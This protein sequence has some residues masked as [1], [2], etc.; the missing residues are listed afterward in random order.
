MITK[1]IILNKLIDDNHYSIRI[2]YLEQAGDVDISRFTATVSI[3]PGIT[4]SYKENDVVLVAFEDRQADKPVILG[5]L[6][7]RDEE[8]R[9][10][11]DTESLNVLKSANLPKDT[12]IDNYSLS[13]L[14]DVIQNLL[15]RE[16]SSESLDLTIKTEGS[17]NAI[18]KLNY[19]SKDS[20]LTASKDLTFLTSSETPE[21]LPLTG[22]TLKGTLNMSSNKI[23]SL[24]T[25]TNTNDATNKEY[26][27]TNISSKQDKITE[28]SKLSV[29]LINGLSTVATTGSYNDLTNRPTIPT[30]ISELS[31][32]SDYVTKTESD[33][34]YV[35]LLTDQTITGIKTFKAPI[36]IVGTEQATTIYKTANGGQIIFGKEADNSGTMIGLDQVAG[37][38]R[39]NFRT[40]TVAGAVVWEQPE[41]NSTFYYDVDNVRFRQSS[42]IYFSKITSASFLGTN[43]EGKVQSVTPKTLTFTGAV[44]KTYNGTEAVSVNISTD[45]NTTYSIEEGTGNTVKLTGSDGSE[46]IRTINNVSNASYA[47]SAEV[48]LRQVKMEMATLSHLL[49]QKVMILAMVY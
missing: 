10:Y 26:V 13:S 1:A 16:T 39:L 11:I 31:N 6:F 21:Y 49:M 45:T 29:N 41:S 20:V 7:T 9:G 32:D 46:K 24:A 3:T 28:D 15:D 12:K 22:G 4:E 27:D 35:T 8:S 17:G 25:P 37:T 44:N 40:S 14:K 38:R 48:L 47:T 5:K 34:K 33:N 30:K 18:T 43:S 36:N 23:T 42:G 19:N 2:P